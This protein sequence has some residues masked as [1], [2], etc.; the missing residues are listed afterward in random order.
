MIHYKHLFIVTHS[1]Q[2]AGGVCQRE[3]GTRECR[4]EVGGHPQKDP[5]A[6]FICP[7]YLL[8]GVAVQGVSVA[9]PAHYSSSVECGDNVEDVFV[10]AA[11][12]Y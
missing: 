9:K 3:G 11:G 6:L 7:H 8:E 10:D 12:S 1:G 2:R 5:T 4:R